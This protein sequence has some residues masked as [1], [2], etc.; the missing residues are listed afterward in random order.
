MRFSRDSWRGR[1][2]V[3]EIGARLAGFKRKKEE[4]WW[5]RTCLDDTVPLC[6]MEKQI[7]V[8]VKHDWDREIISFG[9][10]GPITTE[11][12]LGEAE[13]NSGV[14]W[15]CSTHWD[16]A[17][18]PWWV[19]LVGSHQSATPGMAEESQEDRTEDRGSGHVLVGGHKYD[20]RTPGK[21][22][23]AT[24]TR[25]KIWWRRTEKWSEFDSMQVRQLTHIYPPF[26]FVPREGFREV[27]GQWFSY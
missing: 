11:I 13:W 6:P 22:N 10:V 2:S 27:S 17:L 16:G 18:G 1:S 9:P 8:C 23:W 24:V 7:H 26:H 3:S 20:P 12:S 4:F 25:V 5:G 14:F 19:P 15:V 21:M